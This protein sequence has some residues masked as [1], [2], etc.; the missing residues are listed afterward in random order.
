MSNQYIYAHSAIIFVYL[1]RYAKLPDA[2]Q[3][4]VDNEDNARAD[5]IQL[6]KMANDDFSVKP[7]GLTLCSTHSFLGASSDGKVTDG[8]DTG[9]MEIKCPFSV[10]GLNVCKME[11]P[12][13][14][15]LNSKHFCL[16]ATER[17]PSLQKTHKYYA[18]VQGEMAIMGMPW[19]DFVV[20]TGAPKNNM[21]VDRIYFDSEF[22][23]SMMPKLVKFYLDHIFPIFYK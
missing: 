11:V 7:T 22:V 20:W 4:G 10:D 17:G 21:S 18:Q 8:N 13:I 12:D 9:L 19:C 5:Y 23:T 3:W 16:V 6:N 14:L 1:L 15:A 2:V